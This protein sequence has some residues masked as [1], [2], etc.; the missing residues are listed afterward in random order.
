MGYVYDNVTGRIAA[1]FA[2]ATPTPPSGFTYTTD[3]I[4]NPD[5]IDSKRDIGGGVLKKRDGL[6]LV[7]L[8]SLVVSAVSQLSVQKFDG[9]TLFDKTAPTDN[10]PIRYA[11]ES[12][13][14]GFLEKK[15]AALINGAGTVKVAPPALPEQARFFAFSEELQLLDSTV[16]VS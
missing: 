6:K 13:G 15:K 16:V 3:A 14:G 7:G 8:S 12:K 5:I 1:I 2:T 11:L 10:D 4:T 9:T